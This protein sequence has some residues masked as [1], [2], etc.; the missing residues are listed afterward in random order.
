[1]NSTPGQSM[2]C[3]C[4]QHRFLSLENQIPIRGCLVF[5]RYTLLSG[6]DRCDRC[7]TLLCST[8]RQ[9]PS[10]RFCAVLPPSPTIFFRGITAT[11]P[12][13]LFR[14]ITPTV[15]SRLKSKN[16][17]IFLKTAKGRDHLMRFFTKLRAGSGCSSMSMQLRCSGVGC[18]FSVTVKTE[19][20]HETSRAPDVR[21]CGQFTGPPHVRCGIP[22]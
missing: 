6:R 12:S 7:G 1:M 22:V 2:T 20:P 9:C 14:G 19:M 18:V 17:T 15:P 13:R 8:D 3:L 10:A 21:S 11:V 4:A 5:V 16:L